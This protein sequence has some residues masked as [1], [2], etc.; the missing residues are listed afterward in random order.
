MGRNVIARLMHKRDIVVGLAILS[1]ALL[2]TAK[3]ENEQA[4]RFIEPFSVIDGDTLA[5]AGERLRIEGIDAPELGQICE[6]KDG[7]PYACGV[8]ARRL[9]AALVAN[10]GWE[11]SGTRRDRH[12]RLL[13]VCKRGLDDLGEALVTQG[14]AV[15]EG[16]Y[17]VAEA[18]A[19]AAGEGIWTGRF[20]RPADWRRMRRIEVAEPLAWVQALVPEG[21]SRWFED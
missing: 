11:C 10:G 21:I 4:F 9:L 15:A 13:V 20:E 18:K 1:L 8:E 2:I 17:L 5:A 16:R 19:R 7:A 3:L 12:D 14:Y 6:S